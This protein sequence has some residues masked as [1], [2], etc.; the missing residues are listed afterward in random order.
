MDQNI[1]GVNKKKKNELKRLIFHWVI[2]KHR[3]C[4]LNLVSI[5]WCT[6]LNLLA[7]YST[8]TKKYVNY[9]ENCSKF[10]RSKEKWVWNWFWVHSLHHYDIVHW[11]FITTI[12]THI[13]FQTKINVTYHTMGNS[14]TEH[15]V[16]FRTMQ[17]TAHTM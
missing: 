10:K 1:C 15:A 13:Y 7:K 14:E 12:A 8:T 16:H 5:S 6:W 2:N 17:A 3:R 4:I 9:L 11:W